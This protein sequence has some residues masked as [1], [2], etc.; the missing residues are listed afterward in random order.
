MFNHGVVVHQPI[1]WIHDLKLCI[2]AFMFLNSDTSYIESIFHIPHIFEWLKAFIISQIIVRSM[3]MMR[4]I[5]PPF[6]SG[7]YIFRYKERI[8]HLHC[9]II[10]GPFKVNKALKAYFY[11]KGVI[12]IAD[13][14]GYYRWWPDW[15]SCFFSW[16]FCIFDW[17]GHSQ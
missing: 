4:T 11:F 17:A 10:L 3:F 9:I 8:H 14:R 7:I 5:L 6:K 12:P 2:R 13:V 15:S 16:V 1:S